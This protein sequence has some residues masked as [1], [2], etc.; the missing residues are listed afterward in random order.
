MRNTEDDVDRRLRA[1]Y[2]QGEGRAYIPWLTTTHVRS[3]GMLVRAYGWKSGRIHHFLSMLEASVFRL[4]EWED[5]V[6]EI[7]EQFPLLPL[8]RT[9]KIAAMMGAK[10]PTDPRSG[11]RIVMTTDLLVFRR[12]AAGIVRE[13]VGIKPA[14][15]LTTAT[16]SGRRTLE[17]LE[18][19]RRYWAGY[20]I[21]YKLA[22][23][24][25]LPR[26]RLRNI[27]WITEK[28]EL[29]ASDPAPER[30]QQLLATLATAID[31]E[32]SMPLVAHT[33]A[34]DNAHGLLRGTTMTLVRHAL[35]RRWWRVPLDTV[36][37]TTQPLAGLQ[38]LRG[39]VE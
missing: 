33:N 18:I 13:A 25:H 35:A 31:A 14:L 27:R 16:R 6:V 3:R 4:L 17:K 29:S 28:Y 9:A 11:R 39:R 36:I 2:G 32:P 5:D 26:A 21:S 38:V 12:T 10:H 22:T 15:Q 1:G 19:E 20:L 37:N 24:R 8:E 34:S 30:V 23:D 7:R